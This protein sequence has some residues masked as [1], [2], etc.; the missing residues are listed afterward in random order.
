MIVTDIKTRI[1][2]GASPQ[3]FAILYRTNTNAR[4]LFERFVASCL[5][6]SFAFEGESFY[7]RKLVR[8]TLA[9]LRLALAPDDVRALEEL[10]SVLYLK[11][12]TMHEVK[13]LSI[14]NDCSLVEALPHLNG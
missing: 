2:A 5:P 11:R 14:L 8:K 9:Y 1:E 7:R 13:Q 12:E 3:Q 4:A 10:L 6:F